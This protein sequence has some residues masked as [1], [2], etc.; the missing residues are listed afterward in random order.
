MIICNPDR[1]YIPTHIPTQYQGTN[2]TRETKTLPCL[3]PKSFLMETLAELS[4]SKAPSHWYRVRDKKL[5][6]NLDIVQRLQQ[7]VAG[8]GAGFQGSI[9]L[10]HKCQQ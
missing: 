9:G 5:V 8:K 3:W 4:P 7:T 2:M 10:G 1:K 6:L